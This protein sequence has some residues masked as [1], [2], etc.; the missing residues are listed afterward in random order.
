MVC[1][2]SEYTKQL[3]RARPW[4]EFRQ[5]FAPFFTCVTQNGEGTDTTGHTVWQYDDDVANQ[6][7]E[8]SAQP[9]SVT[10]N[11]ALYHDKPPPNRRRGGQELRSAY[12]GILREFSNGKHDLHSTGWSWETS[13]ETNSQVRH[14]ADLVLCV[15][16]RGSCVYLAYI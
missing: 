11:I 13:A 9:R 8:I 12:L 10:H 3:L 7:R 15:L 1:A 2:A 6:R 5:R 16:C 14:D 4:H